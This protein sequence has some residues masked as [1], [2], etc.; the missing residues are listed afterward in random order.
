MKFSLILVMVPPNLEKL[1][2]N[3]T[4]KHI[5]SG[6]ESVALINI[7]P[8]SMVLLPVGDYVYLRGDNCY[9]NIHIIT[10]GKTGKS[11]F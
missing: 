8:V 7:D 3:S 10:N 5:L 9:V 2:C 4:L 11:W 6:N 1:E